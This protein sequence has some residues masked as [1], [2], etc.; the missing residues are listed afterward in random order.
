METIIPRLLKPGDPTGLVLVK[1]E[2]YAAG[3]N[4]FAVYYVQ[5]PAG[6]RKQRRK[7]LQTAD[8]DVAKCRRNTF[9]KKLLSAGAREALKG[10]RK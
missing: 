3:S 7:S 8:E 2:G 9:Y 6:K 1:N 5:P 10:G 4:Y